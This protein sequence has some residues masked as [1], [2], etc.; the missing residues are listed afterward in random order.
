RVARVLPAEVLDSRTWLECGVSRNPGELVY[1]AVKRLDRAPN[2]QVPRGAGFLERWTRSLRSAVKISP[3]N[4]FE[5]ACDKW[6]PDYSVRRHFAKARRASVDAPTVLLPS[7]YSNVSRLLLQY[8][9]D[10][11]EKQFLLAATRR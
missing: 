6:D 7:A 1:R 4:A 11:P 5:I 8:A 3:A 10:L 9:A 2:P